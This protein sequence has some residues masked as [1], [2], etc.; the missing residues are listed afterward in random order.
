[1][2]DLTRSTDAARDVVRLGKGASICAR[3]VV[4]ATL[5]A[6]SAA[7]ANSVDFVVPPPVT[8]A[9]PDAGTDAIAPAENQPWLGE[10]M[11]VE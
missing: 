8:T 5:S 2:H 1:M 7:D 4:A 11:V 3:I 9:T 6:C 10:F